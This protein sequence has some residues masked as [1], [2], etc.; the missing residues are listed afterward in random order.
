MTITEAQK[1]ATAKYQKTNKER[2]LAY[3]RDWYNQ[4][5]GSGKYSQDYQD[6]TILYI[7]KLWEEPKRPYIRRQPLSKYHTKKDLDRED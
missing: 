6:N 7:R 4:K 5:N 1:I 2:I 3:K